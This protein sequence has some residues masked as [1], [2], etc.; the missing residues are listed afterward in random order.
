MLV[1]IG[2]FWLLAAFVFVVSQWIAPAL[3]SSTPSTTTGFNFGQSFGVPFIKTWGVW[4]AGMLFVFGP[5]AALWQALLRGG[6]HLM[7]KVLGMGTIRR[8]RR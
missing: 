4:V 7:G 2:L 1:I 6:D 8:S 5:F 3:Y